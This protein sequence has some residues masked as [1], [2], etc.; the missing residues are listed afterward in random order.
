MIFSSMRSD[1]ETNGNDNKKSL[2][3]MI[4]IGVRLRLYLNE[5][6]VSIG[7]AILFSK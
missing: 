4:I 5:T 1:K 3:L 7:T 2:K 6:N